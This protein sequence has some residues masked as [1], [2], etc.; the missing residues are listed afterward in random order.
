MRL[1]LFKGFTL[2]IIL[3]ASASLCAQSQAAQS[4]APNQ[5]QPP[6]FKAS[7]RAVVVDVVVTRGSG[8]PMTAL[9]KQSFHITE[10]GKPQAIDYFEEHT[11]KAVPAGALIALP[12][13]PPNVYT[14]V[15]PAPPSDAINVL[16]L[17]T[18][19][20]EKEDQSNVHQQILN[21]L[22][23]MQPGTRAAIFTLGSRLRFIQGF[24]TDSSQLVAAL[25]DKNV[26]LDKQ[27]PYRSTSDKDDD[28]RVILT[29]TAMRESS[30][31]IDALRATQSDMAQ[32]QLGNRIT[33]TLEALNYLVRYLGGIPGRKN[34]IWFASS[35]PV[36]VFPTST[37]REQMA[38]DRIY[39]SSIRKTADLLTLSQVAVYPV[40][41]QGM[42]NDHVM[43]ANHNLEEAGSGAVAMRNFAQGAGERSDTIMAMEQL[44]ADTGGKAYYNANDIGAAIAHAIDNGS[45]YYTL[46]YSPTNKKMDGK[47][48]SIDVKLTDGHYKLS[49]RRGYNADDTLPTIPTQADPLRPL[50]THGLP[51]TAQVLFGVRV[52]PASPQPAAN[53]AHA[54]KN[55]KLTGP[56]TRYNIDFLIHSSDVAL[57]ATDTS[58]HTGKIQLGLMAYDSEG[59]AVNW[60]GATQ[61]MN[62]APGLYTTLQKSGIPAH[63]EIDLPDKDVYLVTGVYDWT[64]G[65][66]GTLEIPLHPQTATQSAAP[67]KPN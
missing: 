30:A 23:T 18:L 38:N 3:C 65:K 19:N 22:K 21:F 27:P 31:S 14:N 25:N 20:T 7:A 1:H 33:M 10:D 54:G 53:S 62:L 58:N 5:P 34:L 28:Q 13:M 52:L 49:Y 29:H 51:S 15:P 35:F 45:H 47:Y 42:M 64:S 24:T 6:V 46:V 39:A 37:Q 41:A 57:T 40:A 17:D 36:T 8:D 26:P 43:D 44:A 32:F 4:Q 67:V 2:A 12:K 56:V 50:L 9:S 11:S 66:A 60:M 48:R 63:M 61:G 55:P 16:L 59:N